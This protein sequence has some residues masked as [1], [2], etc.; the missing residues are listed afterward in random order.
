MPNKKILVI[1]DQ[2][3]QLR[4]IKKI[5][6]RYGWQAVTADSAEE[7]DLVLDWGY[8]FSAILTDLKMPWYNG[9]EFC[10]SAK[11][12][13]PEIKVYALSGNLDLFDSNELD[14]AGFDGIY[15]KPITL[16]IVEN[17]LLSIYTSNAD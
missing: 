17:I 15:A 16:E 2:P 9:V 6:D 14:E 13:Y 11:S 7:A 3:S 8:K 4:I 12:K 1:D 5:L 10:K